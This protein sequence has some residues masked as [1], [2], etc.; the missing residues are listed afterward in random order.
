MNGQKRFGKMGALP[1]LLLLNSGGARR[2]STA[3][4]APVAVAPYLA[5]EK[6]KETEK[7]QQDN[8]KR[9]TEDVHNFTFSWVEG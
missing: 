9:E 1:S 7:G 5:P 8:G 4:L 6:E 2:Q 3:Q